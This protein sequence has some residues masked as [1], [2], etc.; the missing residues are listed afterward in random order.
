MQRG[1]VMTNKFLNIIIAVLAIFV[2]VYFSVK[3]VYDGLLI[4]K[5]DQDMDS[6]PIGAI[7]YV[8]DR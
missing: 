4:E 1:I 6:D 5:A 2:V 7:T 8:M 3:I